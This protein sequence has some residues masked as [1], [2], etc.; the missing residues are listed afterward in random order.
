MPRRLT[1]DDV[2][3]SF[4]TWAFKREQPSDLQLMNVTVANA[5]SNERPVSFVLYWGKGPRRRPAEPEDQCLN[6]LAT[7]ADRVRAAYARGAE[8]Q[9]IFTDTH[10]QLNGHSQQCM[11]AYFDAVSE[12]AGRRGFRCCRLGDLVSAQATAADE[13]CDETVPED[14]FARLCA[15]AR[16]WFRGDGTAEQGALAYCRMNMIEKRV[17]ERTFAHSIF[18]TFS[19]S[20]LRSLFPPSLPIF[21][22]YSIRRGT[23]TKPWFMPSAATG[24]DNIPCQCAAFIG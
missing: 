17:V 2:L 10:A 6:F 19:G 14:T 21:Y 15:G 20:E 1:A 22:M 9:L 23:A 8:F 18:I 13:P 16:K 11:H 12:A 24:C 4:N 3:R 7:M 5:I